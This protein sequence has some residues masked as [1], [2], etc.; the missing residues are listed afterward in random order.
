M[1]VIGLAVY[2]D[3]RGALAGALAGAGYLA[4][5]SYLWVRPGGIS[6]RIARHQRRRL[7]A[8]L[9]VLVAQGLTGVELVIS[10]CHDGLRQAIATLPPGATWQRCRTQF[11]E[12]R[13]L[14]VLVEAGCLRQA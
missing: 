5:L 14:Q 2:W 9:R 3:Y 13:D 1:G 7:A 11:N 4:V 10:D 12:E 6:D 8:F